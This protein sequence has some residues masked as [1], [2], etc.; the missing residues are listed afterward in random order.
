MGLIYQEGTALMLT[1][2]LILACTLLICAV[3]AGDPLWAKT[4]D[5]AELHELASA[6]L[7]SSSN[8]LS[9]AQAA[10]ATNNTLEHGI[11]SEL[12]H[13]ALDT[14]EVLDMVWRLSKLGEAMETRHDELLMRGFVRVLAESYRRATELSLK[15]IN[16]GLADTER[17]GIAQE[18]RRM[19]DLV[20]RAQGLLRLMAE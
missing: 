2:R 6:L 4:A 18:I 9:L 10:N 7:Q 19:R 5:P 12:S 20:Q 3:E 8:L 15:Q 16:L 13:V 14:S 17:P 11:A 1:P